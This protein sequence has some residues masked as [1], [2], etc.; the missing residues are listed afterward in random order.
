MIASSPQ[1]PASI[2]PQTPRIL[3][4][5]EEPTPSVEYFILPAESQSD[6]AEIKPQLEAI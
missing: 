2:Q 5:K 4:N 3:R 6:Q 1:M